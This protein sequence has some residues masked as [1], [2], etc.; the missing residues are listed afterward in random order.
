MKEDFKYS[1]TLIGKRELKDYLKNDW[2]YLLVNPDPFPDYASN[3]GCNQWQIESASKRMILNYMYGD[4]I[5]QTNYIDKTILDVGGGV[6]LCQKKIAQKYDLSVL[7]I[8][9]HDKKKSA[10]YFFKEN[11][12]SLINADWFDVIDSLDNYDL[13]IANDLFPNSDQRLQE[14]IQK[15]LSKTRNLRILLTYHN[16]LCFYGVKRLDAKEHLCMRAWN[17]NEILAALKIIT[18]KT[19]YSTLEKINYHNESVF[20]NG[21]VCAI[22]DIKR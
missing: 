12:I 20:P 19:F 6:N 5:S 2:I 10:E 8:L 17:G 13:I 11:G 18:P 9:I 4:L 7:D 22:L 3:F 1:L 21:R 15:A 16:L 14:F